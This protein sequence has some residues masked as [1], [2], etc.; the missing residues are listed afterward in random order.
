VQSDTKTAAHAGFQNTCILYTSF[1]GVNDKV[2]A[3]STI[4]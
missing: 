4:C 1:E 2:N 3:Q